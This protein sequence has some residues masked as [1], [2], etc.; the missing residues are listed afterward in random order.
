[1]SNSTRPPNPGSPR[2]SNVC[3]LTVRLDLCVGCGVC[4]PLCPTGTLSMSGNANGELIPVDAGHCRK[5][6]HVCVDACPFLDQDANEDSLAKARFGGVPGIRHRGE[7]GYYL[8]LHAGHTRGALRE[9]ATSG[10]LGRWLLAR[11]LAEHKVDSVLCV[12]ESP[13]P[14]RR[15]EY[16]AFQTPES[17]LGAA[18]SAYYPVEMS[19]VIRQALGREGRFAVVGIPCFLKGLHLAMRHNRWLRERIAFT[20][21]LV[22]GQTK[23]KFFLEYLVRLAGFSNSA[24]IRA[25]FREKDPERPAN[26]HVFRVSGGG[27][28][29]QVHFLG[30]YGFAYNSGQFKP[31]CCNYC[32]DVFAEVA[33]ATIMDAWLPRYSA[34]SQGTSLVLTRSTEIEALIARGAAEGALALEPVSIEDVVRSQ[35]PVVEAKRDY[36]ARRLWMAARAGNPAPRKRV[37]ASR[38]TWMQ[39]LLLRSAEHLRAASFDAMQDQM[40]AAPAGLSVYDGRM[41]GPVKRYRRALWMCSHIDVYLQAVKRRW[42]RFLRTGSFGPMPFRRRPLPGDHA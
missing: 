25:G 26:D 33:D 16:A 24:E 30:P 37:G 20:M 9:Q 21:G 1:M 2:A 8:G 32:D 23:S 40:R 4:V 35:T 18:R 22:C 5:G 29:A 13:A 6:C 36:L 14:E 27:R 10:G 3:T 34:D 28:T 31:N 39:R 19:E 17:V 42:N 15:F 12:R 11:L 38:P 7:T 41:A